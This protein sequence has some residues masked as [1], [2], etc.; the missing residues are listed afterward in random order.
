MAHAARTWS[1]SITRPSASANRARSASP[2][3]A[4]PA[5]APFSFTAAATTS[6]WSAPQPS[7]MFLPSGRSNI[8]RTSA[9]SLRR[10]SGAAR[11]AAPFA[12]STTIRIPARG[13]W[14]AAVT[15]VRYRSR[16]SGTS[17][18]VPRLRSP[19]PSRRYSAS[20]SSSVSSGSL[21][22]EAPKNL[23]P[24]SSAGLCEAEMTTPALAPRSVVMK[25]TA[26]VGTTPARTAL[27][28][29]ARIPSTRARCS[30]SPD[31]LVSRPTTIESGPVDPRCRTTAAARPRPNASSVVR[32][33]P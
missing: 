4:I 16:P 5:S 13:A 7:L 22:P 10:T 9:P 28:P 20:I 12:Q 32:S 31:A 6:G 24:L 15:C 33:R 29:A 3:W 21:K 27:A 19:G 8:G 14:T 30:G 18:T 25:A 17:P 26:G 1:P 11:Y 23:M 2:S